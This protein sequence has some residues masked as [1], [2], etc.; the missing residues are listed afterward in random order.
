[1]NWFEAYTNNVSD[2][3]ETLNCDVVQKYLLDCDGVQTSC[4]KIY[5]KMWY[6]MHKFIINC[7]VVQTPCTQNYAKIVMT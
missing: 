3:N 4:T 5:A 6:L 2:P 7:D 1:M